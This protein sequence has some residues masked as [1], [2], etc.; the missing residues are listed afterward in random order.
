MRSEKQNL[1]LSIEIELSK[2]KIALFDYYG[3]SLA[4]TA[5]DIESKRFSGGGVEQNPNIWLAEL[6]S[7]MRQLF[8]KYYFRAEDVEY[9]S[10]TGFWG[11]IIAIDKDGNS[12]RNAIMSEDTRGDFGVHKIVDGML[13]YKHFDWFKRKKLLKTT[14]SLPLLSSQDALGHILYIKNKLPGIYEQ[15][16]KFLETKDFLIYKLC[17][18][19]STT[20]EAAYSYHLAAYKSSV[21][22][23]KLLEYASI[24]KNKLPEIV[25]E[26]SVVGEL[27]SEAAE[28][29][30]LISGIKIINAGSNLHTS[31]VASLHKTNEISYILGEQTWISQPVNKIPSI[32]RVD[33]NEFYTLFSAQYYRHLAIESGSNNIDSFIQSFS[34]EAQENE[35]LREAFFSLAKEAKTGCHNLIYIP[36]SGYSQARSLHRNLQTG[37][38]NIQPLHTHADYSRAILEGIAYRTKHLITKYVNIPVD[39]IN[40]SGSAATSDLWCEIH[41]DILNKKISQLENPEQTNLQGAAFFAA[42]EKGRIIKED[43]GTLLKIKNIF[44]PDFKRTKKYERIYEKFCKIYQ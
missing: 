5:Q 17:G 24:D 32:F 15:S 23:K 31:L 11:S 8:A 4:Y 29:L 1:I 41:A 2:L 12:I 21:Y 40:I 42:I 36:F 13:T 28:E 43:I 44:E 16:Y 27:S 33:N 26:G 14:A 30:G 6:K 9:I 7:G 37:F 39:N 22:D 10:I 18:K 34:I 3:K 38:R 19:A 20:S 25:K 35:L